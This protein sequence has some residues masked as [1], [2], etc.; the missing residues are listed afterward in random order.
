MRVR[1]RATE[2]GVGSERG[3]TSWAQEIRAEV[4]H[5]CCT[6]RMR[7]SSSSRLRLVTGYRISQ[8]VSE[9]TEVTTT[10][11]C[12]HSETVTALMVGLKW[13]A[14]HVSSY[15]LSY[16]H[17]HRPHDN[18][19]LPKLRLPKSFHRSRSKARSEIGPI[20]GQSEVDP[21]APRPTESTPE[22][23]VGTSILPPSTPL[24]LR[25]QESDDVETVLIPV[26]PSQPAS[27]H[28]TVPDTGSDRI[29]PAPGRDESTLPK[30]SDHTTDTEAVPE[31]KSDWKSTAY[32]ATKLAIN[33]AKESAD[34]FPPL[35]S[36]V[37]GLSAV[38]DHCEVRFIP[39]KLYRPR[40]SPSS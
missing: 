32:A 13:N 2:R 1:A 36:V 5:V 19:K 27:S 14:S 30:P 7:E 28:N 38:L 40:Y 15:L 39:S 34:A 17:P 4:K 29:P 33:L 26:D 22:L 3:H 8:V 10:G 21:A 31:N 11:R 12:E 35:K 25:D 23:R 6:T 16:H 24:A 18:M 20:E 9:Y 37:G